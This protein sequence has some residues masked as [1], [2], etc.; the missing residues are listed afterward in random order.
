MNKK[1]NRVIGAALRDIRTDRGESQEE[2]AKH[3]GLTRGFV[4]ELETGAK[5][6][7]VTTLDR[8]CRK[9]GTSPELLLGLRS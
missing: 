5:D 4:S 8:I 9:T 6:M 3:V 2:F 1:L 7:S